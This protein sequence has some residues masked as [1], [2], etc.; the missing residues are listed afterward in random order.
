MNTRKY[1]QQVLLTGDDNKWKIAQIGEIFNYE[2]PNKYIVQDTNYKEVGIPVLTANK[3]FILGYTDEQEGVYQNTPVIIFDDFTTMSKYVDFP[4]KVKSSAMKILKPKNSEY[5][6]KFVFERM[7]LIP[8]AIGQHKRFYLSEYQF[9]DIKL[10]PLS[11][12][13]QIV[14]IIE[15]WDKYIELLDK[16]IEIKKNTKKYLQQV[17]LTGK[18]RLKGYDGEWEER[19]LGEIGEFKTSSVDKKIREGEQMVSLVNYMD[20]YKHKRINNSTKEDFMKVSAKDEQL[21][22]N[23]LLKGDILFTPSSETPEDIGHSV[24]IEEDLS[25]TVYSYHVMRFRPNIELDL[26]FSHYFCNHP[27]VLRQF[28]RYSS[29]V[30]RFTLSLDSFSRVKVVIP[31]LSEQKAISSILTKSD[32]EIKTLEKQKQLIEQQRKYLINNLVTGKIRINGN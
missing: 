5:D 4:F 25:N 22:S 32:K 10:P 31:P 9:V 15:K 16:K 13:K 19:K 23:N 20:V 11:E 12:Q 24:V 3:S 14:S 26:L 7:Q 2:Q 1:L 28:S 30:T 27:A 29:G 17:L 8:F 18:V 21:I 6:I